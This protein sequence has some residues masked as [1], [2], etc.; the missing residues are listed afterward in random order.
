VSGED[1]VARAQRGPLR[2]S[3]SKTRRR[4]G[5][6]SLRYVLEPSRFGLKFKA[7]PVIQ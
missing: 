2:L 6:S 3:C 1:E 4:L 5:L 7:F